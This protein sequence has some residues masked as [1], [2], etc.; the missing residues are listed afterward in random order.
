MF[1]ALQYAVEKLL[2]T[3]TH[4]PYKWVCVTLTVMLISCMGKRAEH[5]GTTHELYNP[6]VV[7]VVE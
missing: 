7:V 2:P 3:V 4:L 6:T 5:S 1:L